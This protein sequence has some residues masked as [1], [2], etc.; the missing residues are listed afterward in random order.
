[1]KTNEVINPKKRKPFFLKA[2]LSILVLYLFAM[3]SIL[4]MTFISSA[5]ASTSIKFEALK[6][7]VNPYYLQLDNC[8]QTLSG[9][10][11]QE[12]LSREKFRESFNLIKSSCKKPE[13]NLLD[14][15]II[16]PS[17]VTV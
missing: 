6:E 2:T 14:K 10:F 15:E 9:E 3:S 5:T 4:T 8:L 7:K 12:N 11:K 13:I 17:G 16:E 1:M